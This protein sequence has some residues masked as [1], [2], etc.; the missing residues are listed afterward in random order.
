MRSFSEFCAYLGCPLTNIRW[1]WSAI[2]P[3]GT[4]AVFTIWDDELKNGRYV[5]Y[6]TTSRRPG[7]IPEEADH[8]LG[9]DEI[10]RIAK[11]AV[12]EPA[13]ESFGILSIVKDKQAV[14]RQRK[15]YDDNTVFKLK[16]E[17]VGGEFI[18]TTIARPTVASIV[19][20]KL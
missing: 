6:P 10:Q 15:T 9:A 8:R 16:I 2:Y 12:E 19:A 5:L 20:R 1:S 7:D 3:D 4:R 11:R 14:P 18:A 17:H 13:I